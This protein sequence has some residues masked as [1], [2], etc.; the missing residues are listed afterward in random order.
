VLRTVYDPPLLQYAKYRYDLTILDARLDIQSFLERNRIAEVGRFA[1]LAAHRGNLR[2]AVALMRAAI[3][4]ILNRGYTHIITDVF[5]DHRRI[6]GRCPQS[7]GLPHRRHRLRTGSDPQA[8]RTQLPKPAYHLAAR[9][10]V[11]LPPPESTRQ[12]GLSASDGQL[13]PRPAPLP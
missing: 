11:E 2:L 5:E 10:E 4:D 9:S 13:A 1:V 3:E 8:W 7:L 6:R 12:L